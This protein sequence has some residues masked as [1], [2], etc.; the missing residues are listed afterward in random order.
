MIRCDKVM[1]FILEK[2]FY[3]YSD[4]RNSEIIKWIIFLKGQY[5]EIFDTFSC[6]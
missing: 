5:H 6:L 3:R 1:N 2:T 4:L